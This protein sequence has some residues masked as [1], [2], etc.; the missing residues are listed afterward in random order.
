MFN[1]SLNYWTSGDA[2]II[3][4]QARYQ[5]ILDPP[6]STSGHTVTLTYIS[7]PV[8]VYSPYRAYNLPTE[9]IEPVVS[10]AAWKYKYR[11]REP[12]FGDMLYR[13][14]DMQTRELTRVFNAVKQ[15]N[16]IQVNFVKS[17]GRERTRR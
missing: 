10:Y 16:R 15:N 7:K 3:F 5:F 11:D 6:P 12:I 14:W 4:P 17:S 13:V 9:Y 2:Y 8:P 1:G